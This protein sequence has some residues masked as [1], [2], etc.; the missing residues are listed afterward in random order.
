MRMDFKRI[1]ET[2]INYFVIFL[3][4]TFFFVLATIHA[5]LGGFDTLQGTLVGVLWLFLFFSP[6]VDW[7]IG[8]GVKVVGMS[9]FQYL[10]GLIKVGRLGFTLAAT[11]GLVLY[12]LRERSW[13]AVRKT[14]LA[15]LDVFT[16]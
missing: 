5:D 4:V 7:L 1:R 13:E 3:I 8:F 16:S 14:L 15:I 11:A 12:L 10:M 9:W 2:V 6:V